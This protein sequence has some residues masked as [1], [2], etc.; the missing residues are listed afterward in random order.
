MPTEPSVRKPSLPMVQSDTA[1][2]VGGTLLPEATCVPMNL[3]R[4]RARLIV[5]SVVMSVFAA[6]CGGR[7]PDTGGDTS[8]ARDLAQVQ[9]GGSSGSGGIAGSAGAGGIVGTP[10]DSGSVTLP[11]ADTMVHALEQPAP[12]TIPAGGP[13]ARRLVH[14]TMTSASARARTAARAPGDRVSDPCTSPVTAN[15]TACLAEGVRRSN[16]RLDAVSV[17]ISRAFRK[18][19]RV[20]SRAPD[21]E[22]LVQLRRSEIQWLQ[23]RDTECRRRAAGITGQLWAIPRAKCIAEETES[24]VAELEGI[25]GEVRKQ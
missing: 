16:G 1:I 11:A 20:K 18:R 25:L 12:A 3:V 14:T 2:P 10:E 8:L 6:G 23:W 9:M 13:H 22:Y 15:Q 24:R 5:T 7:S 17:S 21:P 4:I 19:Q